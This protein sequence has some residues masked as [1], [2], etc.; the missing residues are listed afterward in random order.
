MHLGFNVIQRGMKIKFVL[1]T[2]LLLF[3]RGCDFYSTS[4]WFFD[5]PTGEQ[6]LF[7]RVLGFGWSG[8]LI[9]NA[10]LVSL[11]IYCFYYYTYRYKVSRLA[12][13][14]ESLTDYISQRYYNESGMFYK[15]FYKMPRNKNTLLGHLGYVLIRT[16]II[17]SFLATFHNL[18]Q[19]YNVSFYNSY[20]EVVGRPLY[21]VYGLIILSLVY[22]MFRLW[23][24]EYQSARK[25]FETAAG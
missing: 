19:F 8:L 12:Q 5:N 23:N 13:K 2:S 6:N 18:C 7:Y 20:R 21:V 17:G 1:L 3:A 10:V 24:A 9:S 11:I 14:P 4:L 25:E 16:L 15:V 22:F